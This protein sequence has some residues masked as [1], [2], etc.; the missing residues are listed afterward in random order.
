MKRIVREVAIGIFGDSHTSCPYCGC[1][2]DFLPGKKPKS[3]ACKHCKQ[4]FDI[5]WGENET[6]S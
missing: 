3:W 2:V 4:E 5:E 6:N 1:P